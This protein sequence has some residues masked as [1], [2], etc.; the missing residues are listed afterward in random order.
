[1]WA[2]RRIPA[3][4]KIRIMYQTKENN[5]PHV[6]R[7]GDTL[8]IGRNMSDE[9]K[10]LDKIAETG[11]KDT[12]V[13]ELLRELA[14][15]P[16]TLPI[17]AEITAPHLGQYDKFYFN[18]IS[19]YEIDDESKKITLLLHISPEPETKRIIFEP[20]QEEQEADKRHKALQMGKEKQDSEKL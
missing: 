7:V 1:M 6:L 12:T 2:E 15:L 16:P 5:T 17:L 20:T 14:T 10:I 4:D 3:V 19:I 13:G 18:G 11:Y 9:S 8:E